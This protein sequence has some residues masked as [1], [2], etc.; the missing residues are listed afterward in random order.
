MSCKASSDATISKTCVAPPVGRGRA[1]TPSRRTNA[2][3]KLFWPKSSF[4]LPSVLGPSWASQLSNSAL[5]LSASPAGL[6]W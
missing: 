1:G 5:T 2:N 6:T 4:R 3:A